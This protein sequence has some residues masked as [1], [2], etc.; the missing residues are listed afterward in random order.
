MNNR[1]FKNL[2]FTQPLNFK[3]SNI[4][5]I[6]NYKKKLELAK[7]TNITNM[8]YLQESG[9]PKITYIPSKLAF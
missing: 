1:Q 2:K 4:L 8:H 6:S 5:L 3:K 7:L 9:K